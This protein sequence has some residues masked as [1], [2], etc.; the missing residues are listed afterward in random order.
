MAPIRRRTRAAVPKSPGSAIITIPAGTRLALVLTSPVSSQTVH[1]GNTI[2]AQV[3]APVA[4]GNSVA[5]PARTFVQDKLN[6]LLRNGSRAQMQLESVSVLFPGVYG[7]VA[8]PGTIKTDGASRGTWP[9]RAGS[10]PRSRRLRSAR[11]ELPW[12]GIPPANG[13]SGM[14]VN[15]LTINPDR[16]QTPAIGA[17]AGLAHRRY[18]RIGAARAQPAVLCGP[19]LTHG[20][21]PAA[22]ADAGARSGH[23]SRAPIRTAAGAAQARRPPPSNAPA[24]TYSYLLHAG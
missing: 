24:R 18:G 4:V 22:P 9:A 3:T 13:S 16:M 14:T 11:L 19:G 1:R 23:G 15:S 5:I 17:M 10:P 6:K 2:F 21:E 7:P 8:G 20:T 12:S